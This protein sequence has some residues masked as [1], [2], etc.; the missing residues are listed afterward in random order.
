MGRESPFRHATNWKILRNGVSPSQKGANHPERAV[1]FPPGNC[2]NTGNIR[3]GQRSNVGERIFREPLQK[4]RTGGESRSGTEFDL[5]SLS[6]CTECA[7]GTGRFSVPCCRQTANK[8]KYS[9]KSWLIPTIYFMK[10]SA[11]PHDL[12]LTV[13]SSF[14]SLTAINRYEFFFRNFILWLLGCMK[15]IF[16]HIVFRKY[17]DTVMS[18]DL[19][20]HAMFP[21]LE[22]MRPRNIFLGIIRVFFP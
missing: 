5:F 22:I 13:P 8:L 12:I 3:K 16:R 7:S 17:S 19:G 9:K 6:V 2:N 21:N 18:G 11:Y 14:V 15:A 1:A 4:N 10:I 20:G